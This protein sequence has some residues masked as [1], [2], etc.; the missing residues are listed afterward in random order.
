MKRPKQYLFQFSKK[1]RKGIFALAILVLCVQGSIFLYVKFQAKEK[2]ELSDQ[3]KA[4][5][6][7]QIIL[8]SIQTSDS[9][10]SQ[11]IYPFNPNFLTDFKGYQLGMSVAE[12]DRLFAF[13]AKN[14]FV[15]SA[16]EF[17]QVT[18]ISDSLLQVLSPYFKFPAWTQQNQSKT[19]CI[20]ATN[21]VRENVKQT[22]QK[23]ELNKA[24]LTDLQK[25]VGIGPVLSQRIISDRQKMQAFVAWEQVQE[26]YGLSADVVVAL[27]KHFEISDWS[28]I[29]KIDINEA[30]IQTI[31]QV[32]YINYNMAKQ[33]VIYRSKFGDFKS[34]QD[35]VAVPNFPKEKA[36]II[37]HYITFN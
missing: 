36:V 14:K 17:Q 13:R 19:N 1:Q 15:N 32:P 27:Q 33:I 11:T 37:Q 25:V 8:D 3:D 5:L 31:S 6:N 4:W 34:M 2:Y 23:T 24:T 20:R 35:L 30:D 28:N 21:T 26:I 29:A 18:Q 12:I 22:V 7:Q 9:V 16:S 10:N